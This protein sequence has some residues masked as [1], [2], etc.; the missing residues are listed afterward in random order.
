MMIR[1]YSYDVYGIDAAQPDYT[2]PGNPAGLIRV[3]TILGSEFHFFRHT[4][5]SS[6]LSEFR[7]S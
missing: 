4:F 3:D 5:P 2:Y 1:M 7:L 6:V